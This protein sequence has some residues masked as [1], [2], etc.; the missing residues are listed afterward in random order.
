MAAA[1]IERDER[2]A[3]LLDEARRAGS[4]I[5]DA[6]TLRHACPE[7]ADEVLR[8][9]Q[10]EELL[11]SAVNDWKHAAGDETVSSAAVG[12]ANDT[13]PE[14]QA[15]GSVTENMPA[16]LSRYRILRRLG[17]GGMGAVYAAQDPQLQRTVAIK[18]PHFGGTTEKQQ[19]SRRRFLR[20]AR[21]G[22]AVDHPNVCPIYDV[23]E[24]EGRPFVVMAFVDGDSL[25]D[26]MK[27]TPEV[28][29]TSGVL[30]SPDV[31]SAAALV[32]KIAAGLAAV[33]AHGIVHR[34]L[35]PSNILVRKKDGE[36]I[37]TDFGLAQISAAADNLTAD[38]M[39]LGTP[40]YMS[41]EQADPRLGEVT[42]RSDLYSLGV[43]LFEM[44]TGRR[45]FEGPMMQIMSQLSSSSA[46]PASQF[47]ADLDPALDAIIARAMARNPADRFAD[48]PAFAAALTA[49]LDGVASPT[50]TLVRDPAV[51]TVT[52]PRHRQRTPYLV[53]A[54]AAIVVVGSLAVYWLRKD[55]QQTTPDGV[56]PGPA[57]T[58]AV[59]AP[60]AKL[61]PVRGAI[62]VRVWHKN[63]FDPSTEQLKHEGRK[64]NDP[65]ALPM[66]PGDW[67][68]I[69]VSLNRPAYCYV[70][71]IDTEGRVTPLY[72][73]LDDDWTQ[74][75]KT[76]TP[77]D[78]L[79]LPDQPGG[80]LAAAPL[81]PGPAGMET[82]LLLTRDD[83]LPVEFDLAGLIGQFP[84]QKAP[85]PRAAAWF[86]NGVLVTKEVDRGPIRLDQARTID[87]PVLQTQALLRT[88]LGDLFSYTRAVSFSNRGD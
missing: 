70:V 80:G 21:S 44:V 22:A 15:R 82:L 50:V 40:A 85:N 27:K 60:P 47:R 74:R 75:P 83:P 69:D 7:L 78:R 81:G 1:D 2:V 68:R 11:Q 42:G 53:A 71:W 64:L 63:E 5:R 10:T 9:R 86:E 29:A 32:A 28:A 59:V 79:I 43:I 51:E 49:W 65:A 57:K 36:P 67:L 6:D 13:D 26:R 54:A 4:T 52:L 14:T 3:Q 30:R 19:H 23:G 17:E 12:R 38:G 39:I 84:P 56:L 35:K 55:S 37:L 73:W 87:N 88:K 18:V 24:H 34:D 48:A 61:P 62:D 72:P 25:T 31:R 46:P 77:Q 8:L 76:E 41:P 45:P 66:A 58:A 20:E 16:Q 33:H